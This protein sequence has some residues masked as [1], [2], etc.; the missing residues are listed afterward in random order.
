MDLSFLPSLPFTLSYPLL[1]GGLLVAG[2]LGGEFA[3]IIHAPRVVGYVVVGF[4]I[5]PFTQVLGL[6]P[7]LDEGRIFVDLALGL[8]LFDLGRRMDLQWMRRDWTLAACGIAESLLSF[9]AV[10]TA[11]LAFGFDPVKS[12]LAAAIAMTTSPEVLLMVVHDTS[13]EGQVTE[14]AMNMVALNGLFASILATI[15]LGSAHYEARTPIEVAILHPLYLFFGSLLLGAVMAWLTRLIA[16]TV[17][18]TRDVHFALLAGMVVSAVGLAAML[19]LPVI[20]ALLAFGLFARNDE[21]SYDLLNVNLAPAGRLLYIVLFVITG[22]SLPLTALFGGGLAGLTVVLARAGGKVA[23]VLALAP[24]GG[25]SVRQAVG[26]TA[27]V[28]PMSSLALL[29]EHDIARLFPAFGAELSGVLLG[30]ILAMQIVGPFA[31]QWGLRFAGEAL[32]DPATTARLA[33]RAY[34]VSGS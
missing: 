17:E 9:G 31:V 4:I 19:K 7:L 10:L 27:A 32:P 16:R 13:S 18:K 22:A 21:R 5:G 25:M 30:A 26:L 12:A 1:F 14:R 28:M 24:I 15:L 23:A 11:L 8:V 6:R 2:M 34:H 3:R 29:L 20:L 33:A